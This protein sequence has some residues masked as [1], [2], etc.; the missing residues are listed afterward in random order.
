MKKSQINIY[1][2]I[3]IFLSVLVLILHLLVAGNYELHRDAYLYIA[4]GDHPA[5]GYWSVPPLTAMACKVLRIVFGE[6]VVTVRL[7]PALISS[8]SV[9]VLGT[10]VKSLGGKLPAAVLAVFA[11][12]FSIA[13]LRSNTLL[14]PV[15]VD[16]FFWLLTFF[17]LIKLV[18]TE[19]TKYW[20]WLAIIIGLGFLTKYSIVFLAAAILAAFLFSG[21]RKLLWNRNMLIAVTTGFIIILPNIYWQ[22]QH[23]WVVGYHMELLRIYQLVHVSIPGFILSIILMN[24]NSLIIWL[25]GLFFLLFNSGFR[26]YRIIGIIW[27]ISLG[28][29]LFLHGKAYYTLGLYTILFAFGGVIF[30]KYFWSS[31]RWLYYIN[32]CLIPLMLM[33]VLP[34]ALP[35][36]SLN[37][38]EN[39]C[40]QLK[41]IGLYAPMQ[42]EDGKV[43]DIPQDYADMTGWK[44]LAGMVKRTYADLN[45]NQKG[46]TIIYAENYGQAGAIHYYN[47]NSSLPEPVCFNGS[48]I[49]WAPDSLPDMKYLIY[50]N[51]DTSDIKKQF[52]NVIKTGQVD[53]PYFREDHLPVWLCSDPYDRFYG[54]YRDKVRSIKKRYIRK[55]DLSER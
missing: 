2:G 45:E 40:D 49:F 38:L 8:L 7:L 35:V 47:K 26:K 39:Y 10:A 14:Q 44:E 41:K 46:K 17:I 6:S 12:I 15:S 31:R 50:V 25:T 29:I 22:Y 52:R 1:W 34:I 9:L 27:T 36:L 42:W 30:E 48:F 5:W 55:Y 23:N 43:Y 37:R 54:F 24:L 32:V 20:I 21:K 11:F 4:Q 19:N 33:P 51:D 16:Q 28:I 13:Y 53:N 18:Q 3:I